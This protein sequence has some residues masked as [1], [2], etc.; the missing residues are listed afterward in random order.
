MYVY[1]QKSMTH[2]KTTGSRT[3]SG[4]DNEMFLKRALEKILSEKDIKRTQHAQL[5]KA[6]ETALS[7]VTKE[8]QNTR[9]NESSVLPSITVQQSNVNAEKYF[10]PFELACASN[11][12]RMVETSLDCLQKLLLH[13]HLM[14]TIPDPMD[15]SKLLIDR[16]V[17]TICLCF[18]GVQTEEQVELQIIK[19]LLT[20]MTSQTIEIHQ[21]SVLQIIKTCFN[22]YLTSRSKI[23]EATAQGSLSQMLNGIFSKMEQKLSLLNERRRQLDSRSTS[24]QRQRQEPLDDNTTISD[25]SLSTMKTNEEEIISESIIN[26]DEILVKDILDELVEKICYDEATQQQRSTNLTTNEIIEEAHSLHEDILTT[27]PSTTALSYQSNGETETTI[28][29]SLSS[30]ELSADNYFKNAFYVFR[31][32]CKLSD[33]DI[34]DKTNTDPRTNLDLKSRIFSLRLIMQILQTSGPTFR[35]SEDFLNVIKTYLCVSLSRNGVSAI[36]ELFEMALYNFVELLDKFKQHLKVQIEVLFREIF[37][38]ILETTTSSFRHKWLVIQTLAKISADAQIIVDLFINYDCSMRS[39]NIFERLVIVLSRAAQGRQAVELG[40]SQIEEH[41]LRMKGLECL[42]SILRCM[43]DWSKDLYVN[44]HLQSNLGPDTKPLNENGDHDSGR[45]SSGVDGSMKRTDSVGSINSSH[46][47]SGLSSESWKNPGDYEAVRQRKELFEKGCDIFN[48]DPKK[49]LQFLIDK[50]LVHQEAEDVAQFFH[51]YQD[52]LDKTLIGDFLG[53]NTKY[54]KEVMYVYIDQLDFNKMDF[55]AALRKFLAG[56]RLPGEAQKIDRL[57][58]KFAARY[59]ECNSNL[60]IFASADAAYVLAYSVIMLTTDLHSKNVKKKMTKEQYIKMNRGINESRDLPEEFLSKIY[61]EIENEEIKLKITTAGLRR[62]AGVSG[63]SVGIS[64]KPESIT[65]DKQR[66]LLFNI[67]M[68]D[69]EVI[70]RDLMSNAGTIRELFTIAK[71]LEHVRPMFQKAWSPCL[72]AFSVGLQD[73]DNIDLAMLCLTGLSYAIRIACIFRM[74]LER[75]A[76]VQALSRFTLL[77]ATSQVT[78][79]KAK[80]VE[81]LKT[82]ITVAQTDGNYLGEAWYEILKCISQLELAQLFGV[83]AQKS[84]MPVTNHH[85]YPSQLSNSTA[86]FNLPFDNLFY[87]DKNPH[88]KRLHPLNEQIQETSSQSIVVSV[89]RIFSGSARLDGDAIVAFVRSLCHVSMDELY[90]STPRMFSLLKVVEIS[91]YNMGRIRLQWSRI[92][93]IVGEHFNKVACNPLQDVAFFAVDSLRQLSMKFLEKG[94][95]LNFRFQK[96]FLKPFEHIMKKNSSSTIHDMVVRCVTH[97]VDSQAKNIKSGWKNIFSVFQMAAA[98][99]DASIVELAFQTCTHIITT[100][101][102]RHFASVL[103]SF[104]DAVKCL[105]EFACNASFPDTSMEAIRLIRQCAKYVAEKPHMFN[106]HAGEDLINVPEEDR[107]WVKGWFPVLFELSCIINR[108]KLDVRT[109]ALTVMF[110]IMKYYGETFTQNWWKELFNVVFRIF[111]NMKLPDTQ[112]EKIEWMT[113]TCNHAL[114]AI[115]DVFTQF[116]DDMA[117]SLVEDL[118][119]Q[120][121]WCVNQDNEQLAKSG[122]NCLENFVIACG[123]RFTPQIWER[124]CACILEIF[125]STLPE[126]LMTWRPDTD[127]STMTTIIETSMLDRTYSSFDHA[128]VESASSQHNRLKHGGSVASLNSSTSTEGGEQELR[129]RYSSSGSSERTRPNSDYRLFQ[130]LTIKCVVQLELIQAIDNIVFYPSTSKKEDLQNIAVAQALASCIPGQHNQFTLSDE[131]RDDQGM[132]QYMSI[133]QLLLL[134]DCLIESH[135]FA[136]TFNS[137]HE[138]RNLLWKS[139][140]RGKAKPNLLIQE[141][142]SIAC[143]FRILFR[144]YNNT[145]RRECW[146]TLR[147]RIIRLT[148]D[149]LEYY[150]TLQS[151]SH[152]DAWTS[153]LL[154]LYSKLLK[155]DDERV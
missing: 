117:D 106:E 98:D 49:G 125:R 29:T 83:N 59:C 94:E 102:D 23:N 31:A 63:T 47:N 88:N 26:E 73:T 128:A 120:L 34:K 123:Q 124:T 56:F 122:I 105:S 147:R 22:I 32:L 6:C 79:I 136:R 133:D 85:H 109:R 35:T 151:E 11:H 36:P 42:V 140:Y 95:F 104:Q 92:W 43:V 37:L 66:Q 69:V 51:S 112:I 103:D 135:I 78:E 4:G 33:R 155:L 71:H 148:R 101:F 100:V 10:L 141:T 39:A 70:A 99:T 144:L 5:K 114:Y 54:H 67:Q 111:D 53:E 15:V 145:S 131:S 126:A 153:V 24:Q 130:I 86:T 21:R 40:C 87:S 13:G 93:E 50:N 77:T 97:L 72:A 1:L 64:G 82:L 121:K 134:V 80:N 57:M 44:P 89:D 18:R 68:K 90:S 14:G 58:E 152:R 129:Q 12:P 107:V 45:S 25:I 60:G 41:N 142:H 116:F 16:I 76:F 61:D 9:V 75:N 38:T 17:S 46:S 55:L 127:S 3:Y 81:C 118:Y 149:T 91:Y 74:E 84:R 138:Q 115:V 30:D 19:A 65:S 27:I 110:E 62:G 52:V 28:S 96:E 7:E 8:I 132:Y 20:I 2:K 119:S 150:L 108:C 48:Q 139:G 154:L 137:N 113:T 143:A 146:D